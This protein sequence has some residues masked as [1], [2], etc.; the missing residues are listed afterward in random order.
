LRRGGLVLPAILV[1]VG[2]VALLVNA[3]LISSASL[4][5][6][7]NLWPLILIVL[8]IELVLRGLTDPVTAGRLGIVV[9]IL[10]CA[11]A[12]TYTT[13]APAR[14]A[15]ER[16]ADFSAPMDG[17]E[18]ATLALEMGAADVRVTTA[19]DNSSQGPP[20]YQAHVS[21]T[22]NQR[23]TATFDQHTGTV[24]VALR[25]TGVRFGGGH[26]RIDVELNPAV[27]WTVRVSGG[28]SREQLDFSGGRLA[29]VEVSGGANSCD[30]VLPS[31]QGTVTLA[32]SGGANSVAVH[33][34]SRAAI[35]A[36]VTGGASSLL[37][38][39]HSSSGFGDLSWQ[40]NNYDG[41]SSRYRLMVSGGANRVVVDTRG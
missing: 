15:G 16:T 38:D 18:E 23:A 32:V 11:G 12:L 2:V 7:A 40:S 36:D 10:A 13:L 33:R 37:A 25:Q 5:K 26:R 8:G 14:P 30:L 28:A 35:R 6:L 3:G 27:R 22:G 29:A 4:E 9:V 41:A 21:Y 19:Q 31:P 1:A 39:G 24:T 20:L 17:R 34:P